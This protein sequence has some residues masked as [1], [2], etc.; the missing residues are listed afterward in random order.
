[1]AITWTQ[2]SI[3]LINFER[4]EVRLTATIVDDNPVTGSTRTYTQT[5]LADTGPNKI[6]LLDRIWRAYQLDLASHGNIATVIADLQQAAIDN[7][8]GRLA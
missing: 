6:A 7:L 5:G 8:N 2:V 3:E 1:M 4:R